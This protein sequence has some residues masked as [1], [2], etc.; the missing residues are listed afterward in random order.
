[1][2]DRRDCPECWLSLQIALAASLGLLAIW[3]AADLLTEP[4]CTTKPTLTTRPMDGAV[5]VVWSAEG[6]RRELRHT[7]VCDVWEIRVNGEVREFD[8]QDGKQQRHLWRDLENGGTYDIAVRG[9]RMGEQG[10]LSWLIG[11]RETI[12]RYGPW[13]NTARVRPSAVESYLSS[14][15]GHVAAVSKAASALNRKAGRIEVVLGASLVSQQATEADVA[16]V[17]RETTEAARLLKAIEPDVDKLVELVGGLDGPTTGGSDGGVNVTNVTI[18]EMAY[19]ETHVFDWNAS[20]RAPESQRFGAVYFG[21]DKDEVRI[22]EPNCGALTE[23]L[24]TLRQ[25]EGRVCVEGRASADGPAS[26]NLDLA[27][28]RAEAVAK[29]LKCKLKSQ[30]GLEF[31]TLTAGE[32]HWRADEFGGDPANRRVDIYSCPA[33]A[34]AP[35]ST[36]ATLDTDCLGAD[37][38]ADESQRTLWDCQ[39]KCDGKPLAQK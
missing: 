22:C 33:S 18:G 12:W 27:E 2:A 20:G 38:D 34:D 19:N 17:A 7:P 15:D 1:M 9:R 36:P 26:Y 23:A 30:P 28:R 32:A 11:R 35:R 5:D 24:R 39:R 25:H 21:N 4:P 31:V 13:S 10:W 37:D 16:I 14:I 3:V 8:M 6:R 29:L